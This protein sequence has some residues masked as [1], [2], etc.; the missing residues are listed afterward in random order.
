M[1][2]KSDL[3]SNFL[4]TLNRTYILEY[5]FNFVSIE[6]ALHISVMMVGTILKFFLLNKV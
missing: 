2:K 3:F 4:V 5:F 6:L 1:G